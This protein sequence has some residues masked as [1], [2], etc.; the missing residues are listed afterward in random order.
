MPSKMD[1]QFGNKIIGSI[2]V[3][4]Y[5]LKFSIQKIK[6]RLTKTVNSDK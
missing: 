6:K 4:L 2:I 3:F 1:M 5:N